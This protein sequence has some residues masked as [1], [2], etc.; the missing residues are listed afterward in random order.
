LEGDISVSKN[1]NAISVEE[2]KKY[3]STLLTVANQEKEKGNMEAYKAYENSVLI[4]IDFFKEFLD[5]ND[6]HW[7]N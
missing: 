5:E 4:F 6:I 7:K 2:L 1:E 3:L